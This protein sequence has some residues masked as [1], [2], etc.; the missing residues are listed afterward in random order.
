[1]I[2][3]GTKSTPRPRWH[4]SQPFPALP[5]IPSLLILS[6]R[7]Q[8]TK[9]L[10]D[11]LQAWPNTRESNLNSCTRRKPGSKP[12]TKGFPQ[13]EPLQSNQLWHLRTVRR[14]NISK[15]YTV[16]KGT[17]NLRYQRQSRKKRAAHW[18]LQ[19]SKC[20]LWNIVEACDCGNIEW[21]WS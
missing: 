16:S 20:W 18:L 2:A 13:I 14:K 5:S 1:M 3:V 17:Q 15:Q 6:Q 19:P 21:P 4:D 12:K 9:A 8:Q 10:K 7:L 11:T